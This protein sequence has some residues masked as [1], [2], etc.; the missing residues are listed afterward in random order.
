MNL[1]AHQPNFFPWLGYFIKVAVSD[2]H[3][4][5]DRVQFTKNNWINRNI[6]DIGQ[7]IYL[8]LPVNKVD[9]N[10]LIDEVRLGKEYQFSIKKMIKTIDNQ[11]KNTKSKLFIQD[12]LNESLEKNFIYLSE[13]NIFLLDHLFKYFKISTNIHKQSE[14]QLN[15]SSDPTTMLVEFCKKFESSNYISGKGAKEYIDESKF[16]SNNIDLIY[17]ENFKTIIKKYNLN[18]NSILQLICDEK[19]EIESLFEKVLIDY[20]KILFI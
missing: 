12:L 17:T 1:S 20:K 9:T 2:V 8:T 11:Y 4:L 19:C 15:N 14:L 3:I 13:I 16:T 6:I 5:L 7:D 10:K 18:S